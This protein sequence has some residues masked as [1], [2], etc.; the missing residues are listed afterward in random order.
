MPFQL[1]RRLAGL[2]DRAEPPRDLTR[3]LIEADDLR[4]PKRAATP[5]PSCRS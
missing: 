2:R 3:L 5:V 4:P 1:R